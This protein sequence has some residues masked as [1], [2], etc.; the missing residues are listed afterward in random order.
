MVSV[1]TVWLA[2]ATTPLVTV[3]VN[4]PTCDARRV[5]APIPANAKPDDPPE[6]GMAV[7]VS[8]TGV[9]WNFFKL[10]QPGVKPLSSGPLCPAS[11]NWAATVVTKAH[12]GWTGSGS[13]NGSPRG[14][15]T[16]FGSGLIR[17]RD[18]KRPAGSSWDH[19]VA[20]AYPGTLAGTYARPAI[21]T[22]GTCKDPD[23]CI[24]EGARIQLDP[25]VPCGQWP[26]LEIWQRQLCRTLQKYGMI[27]V[28]TGS[29]LLIQNPLSVGSYVYPWAPG[30]RTLPAEL[31]TRLRVIDWTKW[32]GP[33]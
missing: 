30:W 24:P 15:G 26:D 13:H 25:A 14:S 19:A 33:S 16:L 4:Y 7:M 8:D 32:T 11:N 23:A 2:S 17:P 9:E 21:H 10:T 6:G 18:T 1:P 31:A 12:P 20:L 3:Q 27:V 5:R 29:A 22:D 28:E